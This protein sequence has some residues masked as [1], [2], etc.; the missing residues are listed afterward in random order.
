MLVGYAR[1]S[2]LDQNPQLQI[3]ALKQALK[4]LTR[5]IDTGTPEGRLFFHIT[6]AFDEFQREPIVEN[7]RAG[8]AAARK[9]GR[10]GGGRRCWTRKASVSP[11]DAQGHDELPVCQRRHRPP[12]DREDGLLPILPAGSDPGTSKSGLNGGPRPCRFTYL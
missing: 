8:L 12:Q 7:T 3:D 9:R 6:A 2:T 1:V 10:R 11:R 4:V 5:N